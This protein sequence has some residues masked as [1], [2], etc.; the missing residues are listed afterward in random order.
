MRPDRD[1]GGM[2]IDWRQVRDRLARAAAA[3]EQALTPTPER[4]RALL[5]ERARELARAPVEA[6]PTAEVLRLVTFT[7]AGERY[8]VEA[9]Y[10]LEVRPLGEPTFIPGAPTHLA[11]VIPFR[12]DPLAVFDLH[13]LFGGPGDRAAGPAA[14]PH[15]VVLGG[16]APELGVRADAAGELTTVGAGEVLPLSA[17]DADTGAPGY[18]RGVTRDALIVLDGAALLGDDRLIIDQSDDLRP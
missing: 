13:A 7:L 8:A 3:T 14:A 12:G 18:V 2:P 15:V 16:D 5:E 1:E 4:V 17:A 10:V 6:S 11:G 9:R